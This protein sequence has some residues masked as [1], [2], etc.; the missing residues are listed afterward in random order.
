MVS[1][2]RAGANAPSAFSGPNRHADCGDC[3]DPHAV[4]N[5]GNFGESTHYPAGRNGNFLSGALLGATGL[6]VTGWQPAGQPFSAAV[7]TLRP[8]DSLTT[9]Y[10]W[11]ICFKCHS[12]FTI[13][14]TL[15]A[16]G[17]GD[18]QATKLTSL[19]ARQVRE[20]QDV[21]Q[22][23]N[24]NN[25]SFHPV[26]AVGRNTTIPAGSFV[27]PWTTT[28]T[29][30][31]ADCH[32]K[33]LG[34]PGASGPHASANMHIL[35][36]PT[37]L[38]ENRHYHDPSWGATLGV[39]PAELCLKCHRWQTYAQ[40]PGSAGADPITNTNFRTGAGRNL[41]AAHLGGRARGTTCYDCHDAHGTNKQ[42]LIN[43]NL[44]YVTA[45]R[46]SQAAYTT[47]G[48]GG[49]CQLTCHGQRHAPTSYAR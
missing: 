17:S 26:T 43:F 4:R 5:N 23:F 30:Y 22:A 29:M 8:L 48:G 35:E 38:R 7:S 32:A 47:S 42:Y 44:A 20:F 28:S 41:H 2:Y 14:P 27:A 34:A 12:T 18:Y 25:L 13:L 21:G 19:G 11:Q 6:K 36:R 10:E 33:S 46:G 9:N 39:D 3:H 40:K 1:L 37:Y 24:P 31:C 49:S 15:V 16:V 45:P